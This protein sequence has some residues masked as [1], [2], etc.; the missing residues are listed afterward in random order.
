MYARLLEARG[1][2]NVE[3]DD[4]V[5]CQLVHV[6]DEE[7]GIL[8]NMIRGVF[9]YCSS[10]GLGDIEDVFDDQVLVVEA[11]CKSNEVLKALKFS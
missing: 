8:K 10:E 5:H 1:G 3:K 11:E 9:K 2:E 4:I 6:I 7:K